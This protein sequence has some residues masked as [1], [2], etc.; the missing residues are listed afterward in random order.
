MIHFSAVI[1]YK[2]VLIFSFSNVF[3]VSG[4]VYRSHVSSRVFIPKVVFTHFI[5][6]AYAEYKKT[7]EQDLG[8][9]STYLYHLIPL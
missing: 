1:E 8:S 7:I 9:I 6:L 2:P 5:P 3:S 4:P